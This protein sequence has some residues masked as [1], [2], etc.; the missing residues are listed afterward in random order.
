MPQSKIS[1][2]FDNSATMRREW[3]FDGELSGWLVAHLIAAHAKYFKTKIIPWGSYNDLPPELK[4]ATVRAKAP[5][6]AC[7]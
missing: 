2:C 3:Y 5:Q 4:N 6:S 1:G 7:P